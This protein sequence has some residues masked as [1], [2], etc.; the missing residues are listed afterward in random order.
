[1]KCQLIKEINLET[2]INSRKVTVIEILNKNLFQI[3]FKEKKKTFVVKL[4]NEKQIFI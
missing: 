4:F 1:M 2:S 3:L